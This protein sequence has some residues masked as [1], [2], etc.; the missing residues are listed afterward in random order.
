MKRQ[1]AETGIKRQALLIPEIVELT[2]DEASRVLTRSDELA[3]LGLELEAFGIGAIC[4]R[5]T[6][7]CIA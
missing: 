6:P 7:P 1:M 4:V 2:E 5:A 3:E